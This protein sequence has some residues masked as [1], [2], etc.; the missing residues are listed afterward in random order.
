MAFVT[1]EEGESQEQLLRRFQKKVQGAGILREAKA[2]RY[3]I[4]KS[5][6]V[7]I[8]AKKIARRRH[9][10]SRSMKEGRER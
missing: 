2:H 1:I 10:N 5:E 7:R 4:P 9:R 3:Y 8:K 6:A